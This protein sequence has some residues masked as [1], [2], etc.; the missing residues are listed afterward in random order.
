MLSVTVLALTCLVNLMLGSF[1]LLRN[2][3]Q[4]KGIVFFLVCVFVSLWAICNYLAA[5]QSVGLS[6][7]NIF[8][9]AAFVFGF[10]A[11]SSGLWF[12]YVFPIPFKI[13]KVVKNSL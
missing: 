6:V 10:L 1:V 5:A 7:N 4:R 2:P 11:I 3:R 12:T 13:S 8:N 9:R